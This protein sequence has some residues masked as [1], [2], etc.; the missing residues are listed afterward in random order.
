MH[1]RSMQDRSLQ[2]AG[3]AVQCNVRGKRLNIAGREHP[4]PNHEPQLFREQLT[5]LYKPSTAPKHVFFFSEE[6]WT[7][8]NKSMS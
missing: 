5:V 7:G 1:R 2:R 3:D 8:R 4:K 6:T